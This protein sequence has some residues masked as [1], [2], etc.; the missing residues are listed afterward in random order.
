MVVLVVVVNMI[1]VSERTE[2]SDVMSS[3]SNS[4]DDLSDVEFDEELDKKLKEEVEKDLPLSITDL[5]KAERTNGTL[6]PRLCTDPCD[7]GVASRLLLLLDWWPHSAQGVPALQPHV[8]QQEGQARGQEGQQAHRARGR[9]RGD[10]PP[11]RER[12][13]APPTFV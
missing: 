11:Q 9:G 1:S 8:G 12:V 5:A 2:S 10:G 6:D 7:P 13:H 3:G 4:G